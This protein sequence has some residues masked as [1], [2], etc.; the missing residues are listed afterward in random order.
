MKPN[1]V[2]QTILLM[3]FRAD[4][5]ITLKCLYLQ[6]LTEVCFLA[7]RRLCN[8][9]SQELSRHQQQLKWKGEEEEL[10]EPF[11]IAERVGWAAGVPP[12]KEGRTGN[13]RRAVLQIS[14]VG[15]ISGNSL[16]VLLTI[17]AQ[18]CPPEGT[19]LTF[20]ISC[21]VQQKEIKNRPV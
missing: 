16:A 17:A 7:A 9:F 3:S 11:P 13:A 5:L 8:L 19:L 10:Q 1:R 12:R 4:L 20:P 18:Q 14:D 6:S 21:Q 2:T 15:V